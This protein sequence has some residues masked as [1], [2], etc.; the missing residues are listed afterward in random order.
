[1]NAL[2]SLFGSGVDIVVEL[3]GADARSKVTVQLEKGKNIELPRYVGDEDV[4]GIVHI[5]L[6]RNKKLEHTGIKVEFI[7]Q[8]VMFYDRGNHFDFT[9]LTTEIA[10]PGILTDG[11]DFPFLYPRAEKIYESYNGANVRLRYFVKVTI[12]RNM[13]SDI[14]REQELWVINYQ[15]SPEVN[16]SLKM[17]VG[18]EDC[19]HIEFEYNKI[20]YHLKDVVI[21]KVYFLLVRT[22]I[23]FMEISL[24]RKEASGQPPNAYNETETISKFEIMDGAPVK[25]ETLPV[26]FFLG[27][28]DLTPTYRNVANKFSVKYFLNLV[29]FDIEDRRYFKQQEINLWRRAPKVKSVD[30]P[31]KSL[32]ESKSIPTE[33][34]DSENEKNEKN[35][36]NQQ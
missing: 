27:H 17:E 4:K 13:L 6:A 28:F 18:I 11:I 34:S 25:G 20:K 15:Q 33:D 19:I 3:D 8:I 7:G 30:G 5:R 12:G 9:S 1:M 24:L 23:K 32:P 26:R 10:P 36:K 31:F 29:L 35:E 22:R 14:T 21:G 2:T 16:P